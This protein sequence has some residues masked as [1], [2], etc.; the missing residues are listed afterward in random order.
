MVF[1]KS[2]LLIVLSARC[3]LVNT[4]FCDQWDFLFFKLVFK[5]DIFRS[6]KESLVISL[7]DIINA[8]LP[9]TLTAKTFFRIS[10]HRSLD[11]KFLREK[12]FFYVF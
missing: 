3:S 10:I 2:D 1:S 6:V 12:I 4:V 5:L 11:H 9:V 8:N 7:I